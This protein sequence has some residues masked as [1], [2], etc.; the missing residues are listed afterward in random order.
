MRIWIPEEIGVIQDKQ[1]F[2][3][4]LVKRIEGVMHEP[5]DIYANATYIPDQIAADYDALW[6]PE[7]M[8]TVIDAAI[9]NEVAIEINDSPQDSQ[10]GL[11]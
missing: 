10:P 8:H 4:M 7:R 5:I 1:A 9:E 3:E 6:T 2:M 11:H